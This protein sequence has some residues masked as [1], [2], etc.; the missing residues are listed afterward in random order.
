MPPVTTVQRASSGNSSE[1]TSLKLL[2]STSSGQTAVTSTR[3][4]AADDVDGSEAAHAASAHA[5][6]E[7]SQPAASPTTEGGAPPAV[8][9]VPVCD[10]LT[11]NGTT[12][13]VAA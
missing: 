5:A 9:V 7:L 6:A 2:S 8:R 1:A 12:A 13:S 3:L 10:P 4:D 11:G